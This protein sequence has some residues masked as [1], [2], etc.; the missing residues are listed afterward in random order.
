MFYRRLMPRGAIYAALRRCL[1]LPS[2]PLLH[3]APYAYAMFASHAIAYATTTIIHALDVAP[4]AA[5]M[6]LPAFVLPRHYAISAI[7]IKMFIE[8][9]RAAFFA[10]TIAI[11]F[12]T[13]SYFH[14]LSAPY[15]SV[16]RRNIRRH[17]AFLSP[18]RRH[19]AA[20]LPPPF[21]YYAPACPF[22][23]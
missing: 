6:L 19:F 12:A 10:T 20:M 23:A 2:A 9:R 8:F 22:T 21:C 13:P 17:A 5:F 15:K 1:R 7:M 14:A 4:T 11:A 18:A 3:V 16:D